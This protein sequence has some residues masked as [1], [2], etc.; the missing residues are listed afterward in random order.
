MH[1][2][3]HVFALVVCEVVL[4]RILAFSP[5]CGPCGSVELSGLP[6]LLHEDSSHRVPY[7]PDVPLQRSRLTSTET[8]A[9]PEL[10]GDT[11]SPLGG[12]SPDPWLATILKGGLVAED[13]G[14]MHSWS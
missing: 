10:T 2:H 3:M 12:K 1:L 4:T 8:G 7:H 11:G 13:F 6:G 14:R 5:T 9:E